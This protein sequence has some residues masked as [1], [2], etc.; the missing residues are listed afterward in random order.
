MNAWRVAANTF[1]WHSPL[2]D[3]I[4][5]SRL[6]QIADWGFDAVELPL[7]NIGDWDAERC[8][9]LLSENK[10]DSVIGAVFGPGRELAAAPT[11]T[12]RSTLDYMR[13]AL[14]LAARQGAD[15]VIGPAYCS[16]GRTWHL[17]SAERID[18]YHELRENYL[19]LIEH[20]I[21]RGVRIAL[22]PLNRYETSVFN[23]TEQLLEFVDSLES[24]II[25]LNLDTYHMNIEE[26]SLGDAIRLAGDKLFHLQVCGN[27]RGAPGGDLTDWEDVFGSLSS[28]GYRGLLGIESFTS[29][30]ATLAR[31]ASIWRSLA[32]TQDDLATN[33]LAFLR[34][35]DS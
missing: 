5:E 27:D 34:T 24:E 22:E 31:A 23:T 35:F 21:L 3:E 2:T 25:G 29:E 8:K 4:L 13:S 9:A 6:P 1:I 33:G 16:V 30:N 17:N 32:R 18:L 7:E 10:L 11:A 20:A 19:I 28:I 12:Q 26:R 14:D 15:L